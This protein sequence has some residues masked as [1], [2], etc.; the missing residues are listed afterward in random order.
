MRM[1]HTY[2][3]YK[4]R[5]MICWISQKPRNDRKIKTVKFLF[6]L[7]ICCQLILPYDY[8]C[9]KIV[10]APRGVSVTYWHLPDVSGCSEIVCAVIAIAY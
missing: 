2:K 5:S 4:Y 1:T 6:L 7:S 3:S 10:F 9:S 8:D